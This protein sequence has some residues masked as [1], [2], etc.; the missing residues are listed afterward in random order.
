M[1]GPV[2]RRLI[3]EASEALEA[4]G[5]KDPKVTLTKSVKFGLLTSTSSFEEARR[6]GVDPMER[7]RSVLG[8]LRL[9]EG[10][11]LEKVEA[12]P[13]GYINFH[14]SWGELARAVVSEVLAA[15]DAYFR[16]EDGPREVVVEHTSV[17]PNKALH[18]GHARNVCI[19]DTIARV[20]RK[21]GARVLV[22]NYVDDSGVQMAELLLG[23]R[24]LGYPLEPREGMR[25]DEYCGD[26]VYVEVNRRAEADP[27]VE[28]QRREIARRIEQR[29]TEEFEQARRV[30]LMVLRDQLKTTSRLGATYDLLVRE[31]DVVV[32]GLWAE[33]FR[34]MKEAG[35][36]RFVEEGPKKG[37]WVVDLSGHPV[38]SKEGDEVLVKSDGATT[39]VARDIA[40]AMWKMGASETRLL[41][42][43]IEL[44]GQTVTMSDV[45]GEDLGP[46]R[47]DL[48][49][50]VVDSRQRRPQEVVRYALERMG[51]KGR[52]V[53]YSYE[54]VALSRR[55]AELLGVK[56]EGEVVHMSGR[57]GLYFKAEE[58]LDKLKEVAARETRARRPDWSE[59]K[60]RE[61]A[62]ALAVGAFRYGM[63]RIESDRQI[64]FDLEESLRLEGDTGPYLQYSVVRAR[65]ILQKA[66]EA[67]IGQIAP[68]RSPPA[69]LS[70][71][72]LQLVRELAV[73]PLVMEE[74]VRTL[75]IRSLVTH[76]RNLAM[77]FNE[78]YERCPV[79]GS[80]EWEGFRLSLVGAYDRIESRLLELLGIPV[81]DEI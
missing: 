26:V 42:R 31:S 8:Q 41:F 48:V 57:R 74:V 30:A 38:L 34:R 2:I 22:I 61:V 23:F 55:S 45:E 60:V 24:L 4:A 25:F 10:S 40:F 43:R 16:V 15:P 35:L 18:I 1:E 67:G 72:E 50:T 51:V 66:R 58:V 63:L 11:L 13:P 33:A 56:A 76:A 3:R 14:P 7:A 79:I 70:E 65:K 37:C 9:P 64:V 59:E 12:A 19:G 73:T 77:R 32:T 62:E 5:L 71:H 52:Y 36:V 80:G 46:F 27:E 17:N 78:F 54:P 75:Y 20:M 39:Y 68:D 81:L 47:S 44:D 69:E 21:A 6:T 28:R 49:V 53:H 29:G